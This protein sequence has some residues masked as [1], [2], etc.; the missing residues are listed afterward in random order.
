[1]AWGP[2]KR[3]RMIGRSIQSIMKTPMIA[4]ITDIAGIIIISPQTRRRRGI[5][6]ALMM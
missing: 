5:Y 4:G 2:P 6:V 1:M 3:N